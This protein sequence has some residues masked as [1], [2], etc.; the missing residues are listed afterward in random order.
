[1]CGGVFCDC[2]GKTTLCSL[3]LDPIKLNFE[4]RP[5]KEDWYLSLSSRFQQARKA[6][7]QE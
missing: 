2:L 1:M 7:K 6:V 5:A 3:A 4:K